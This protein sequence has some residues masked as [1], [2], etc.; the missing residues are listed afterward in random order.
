MDRFLWAPSTL[1]KRISAHRGG[2]CN[3]CR[4]TPAS[5][6]LLRDR[7]IY[8]GDEPKPP[9]VGGGQNP[10]DAEV[11]AL[12]GQSEVELERWPSSTSVR[13]HY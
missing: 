5:G 6:P 10:T 13:I 12:R 2:S 11:L 4:R 7:R 3:G 8:I 1:F 9:P